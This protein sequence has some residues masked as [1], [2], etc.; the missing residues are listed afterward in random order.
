MYSLVAN[1]F[2]SAEQTDVATRVV[3][4]RIKV[5]LS[6]AGTTTDIHNVASGS[7]YH[8]RESLPLPAFCSRATTTNGASTFSDNNF[9]AYTFVLSTQS[10]QKILSANSVFENAKTNFDF[11][12]FS[13][14]FLFSEKSK[15]LQVQKNATL[16]RGVG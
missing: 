2:S 5:E 8:L 14:I 7:A 4:E 9:D 12:N 10:S 13:R 15:F 1:F 6:G 3:N 11:S 16:V